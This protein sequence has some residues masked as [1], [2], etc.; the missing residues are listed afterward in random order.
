MTEN[1]DNTPE[2]NQDE[3]LR[4]DLITRSMV[5]RRGLVD[6]AD[7]VIDQLEKSSG[8]NISRSKLVSCLLRILIDNK[9]YIDGKNIRDEESLRRELRRAISR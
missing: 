9:D 1:T 8:M 6:D 3:T 7:V 4:G 5:I 2:E